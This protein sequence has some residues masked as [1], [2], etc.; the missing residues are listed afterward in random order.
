MIPR[1]FDFPFSP[2]HFSS[3][4]AEFRLIGNY[5]ISTDRQ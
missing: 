4:I 5:K 3:V 2:C 1:Y